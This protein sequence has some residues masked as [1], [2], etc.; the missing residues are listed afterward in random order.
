MAS[1]DMYF[2]GPI[3][4]RVVPSPFSTERENPKSEIFGAPKPVKRMFLAA[5]VMVVIFV[6]QVVR[7]FASQVKNATNRK[8]F[9]YSIDYCR[10][11]MFSFLLKKVHV[12]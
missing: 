4:V 5:V 9:V 3:I 12:R 1:G 10:R 11:G 7:L 6:I 8:I 2:K